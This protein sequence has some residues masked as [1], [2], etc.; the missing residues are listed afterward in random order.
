M[1]NIKKYIMQEIANNIANNI[2]KQLVI[3]DKHKKELINNNYFYYDVI[4]K[5]QI[6]TIEQNTIIPIFV[7]YNNFSSFYLSDGFSIIHDGDIAYDNLSSYL[8][9]LCINCNSYLYI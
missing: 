8:L 4:L 1:D 7:I 6:G 5:K 2:A 3:F 9:N